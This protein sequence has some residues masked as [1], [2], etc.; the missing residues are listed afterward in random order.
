VHGAVQ[1]YVELPGA[2]HLMG[3]EHW[4]AAMEELLRWLR[5]HLVVE[6]S[7]SD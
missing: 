1:R 6:E 3:E 5:V 7:G 4:D 2:V